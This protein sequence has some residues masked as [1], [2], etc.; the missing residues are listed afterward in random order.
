M[1][2]IF[3]SLQP[4]HTAQTQQG[5]KRPIR[6]PKPLSIQNTHNDLLLRERPDDP[7]GASSSIT[8]SNLAPNK[9]RAF[10]LYGAVAGVEGGL[11]S[12]VAAVHDHHHHHHR[13]CCA[14]AA[15]S[16]PSGGQV[17]QH[18]TAECRYKKE[19]KRGVWGLTVVE[20]DDVRIENNT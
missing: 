18:I 1:N 13:S 14:S 11:A 3:T 15:S 2:T 12:A 9:A 19:R 4:Q 10:F 16:A 6:Y 5:T 17:A 7:Q 20:N 8:R